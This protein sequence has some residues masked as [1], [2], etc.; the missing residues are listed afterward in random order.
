MPRKTFPTRISNMIATGWSNGVPAKKLTARIN[1]SATARKLG[2]EYSVR[3]VAA[4]MAWY[5]IRDRYG[6]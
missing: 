4:A 1:N 6:Y 5:T 3:Q 2:K